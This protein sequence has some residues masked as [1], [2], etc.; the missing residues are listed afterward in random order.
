MTM[1]TPSYLGETIEYSS[2]HAC[3][4]TLEDP[5]ATFPPLLDVRRGT[6]WDAERETI[7]LPSTNGFLAE[8]ESFYDLVRHGWSRWVGATPDESIDIALIL[9]AVAVSARTHAPAEVGSK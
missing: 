1:I 3:R 2:L 6:G 9:D 5:T 7:E 4:S 8:A